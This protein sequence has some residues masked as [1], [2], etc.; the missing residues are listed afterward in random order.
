MYVLREAIAQQRVN[1]MEGKGL[2]TLGD[3][4]NIF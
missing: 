2:A 1:V 4:F 3:E